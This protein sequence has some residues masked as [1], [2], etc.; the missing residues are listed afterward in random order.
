MSPRQPDNAN[1][2]PLLT[3]RDIAA[4]LTPSDSNVQLSE[5]H[6]PFCVPL[7]PQLPPDSIALEHTPIASAS[8]RQLSDAATICPE[9]HPIGT[10]LDALYTFIA[11]RT[12]AELQ[13]I[14]KHLSITKSGKKGEIVVGMILTAKK[15]GM[16]GIPLEEWFLDKGALQDFHM[17]RNSS[18][19]LGCCPEEE[20]LLKELTQR[21]RDL[22]TKD[23]D[24]VRS[25]I[26]DAQDESNSN[27]ITTQ[28]P[29][30]LDKDKVP[31]F[32]L[33]EFALV[34]RDDFFF[35]VKNRFNDT[36]LL[37]R[38]DLSTV[39]ENIDSSRAPLAQRSSA[40][41]KRHYQEA[42]KDFTFFYEKWSASGQNDP[43]RSPDFFLKH[44][45]RSFMTAS[46]RSLILSKLFCCGTGN[47]DTEL[48]HL[49]SRVLED[50]VG[51]D[52]GVH[53]EEG[54]EI[55][56]GAPL[57]KKRRRSNN[58]SLLEDKIQTL[59]DITP[60]SVMVSQRQKTG[61]DGSII[62]K[63]LE[64]VRAEIKCRSLQGEA[65]NAEVTEMK[66]FV[67]KTSWKLLRKMKDN[68]N[69]MLDE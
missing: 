65:D 8:P 27:A 4:Q 19:L 5:E 57:R 18:I 33:D 32:S 37:T 20:H 26:R 50:D 29:P 22:W 1:P 47:E 21:E 16:I 64:I 28:A 11:R 38:A 51:Y 31:N 9:P 24:R 66:D 7:V 40:L 17:I 10:E 49:F 42:R 56:R 34:S 60:S 12:K 46:A 59:V 15:K 53:G 67:E 6:G 68:V 54:D 41:L 48:I 14:A 13:D 30:A 69:K 62:Q 39:I 63:Q 52:T 25:C 61:F 45:N 23:L 36:T 58:S 44:P 3:G 2:P 55:P 43:E 35:M